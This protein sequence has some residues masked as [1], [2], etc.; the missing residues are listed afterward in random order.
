[1]ELEQEL[2]RLRTLEGQYRSNKYRLQDSISKH[3]PQTIST[4][5]HNIENLTKDIELRN[6]NKSTTFAM[7]V[8][9]KHFTERKDAG[10]L[11]IP[12]INSGKFDGTK[13][14]LFC[15]FHLKPAV[16]RVA[17]D[18]KDVI[19]CGHGN[20]S[21]EIGTS[22]IGGVQRIENFLDS[23]DKRLAMAQEGLANAQKDLEIAKS[24]VDKPFEHAELLASLNEQLNVLNAELDLNKEK[25]DLTVVDDEQFK[26][27]I[28][29]ETADSEECETEVEEEDVA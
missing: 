28:V 25:V 22:E 23:F 20:Y 9:K 14:A 21:V 5:E 24:E 16:G 4:Y 8:G 11:L 17:L 7:Q 29:T 27:E 2:S 6:A 13:I 1:M 15:G 26:D 18:Q 10:A 3:F 12:A 19:I